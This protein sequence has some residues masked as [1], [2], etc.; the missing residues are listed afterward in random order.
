MSLKLFARWAR[1]RGK[2]ILRARAEQHWV[3]CAGIDGRAL[4]TRPKNVHPARI[5]GRALPTRPGVLV[6]P[7]L[8]SSSPAAG[9]RLLT[10]TLRL[11]DAQ[12]A[13][14]CSL[15]SLSNS[16][17]QLVCFLIASRTVSSSAAGQWAH[18]KNSKQR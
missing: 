2:K 14:P 17:I 9:S 16:A 6:G 10:T 12:C 15:D 7:R 4:L 18:M 11:R 5:D 1:I 3:A 8:A 13:P